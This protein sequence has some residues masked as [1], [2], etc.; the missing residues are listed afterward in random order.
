MLV[1]KVAVQLLRVLGL[2][3]AELAFV[4]FQ[5]VVLFDVLLEALVAGAGEGTLIAAENYSLQ[6]FGEFGPAHFNGDNA[7]LCRNKPDGKTA[8]FTDGRHTSSLWNRTRNSCTPLCYFL[9]VWVREP[10]THV[11]CCPISN[12]KA[13]SLGTRRCF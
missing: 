13:Y 11:Q 12:P 2:V 4:G 5:F 9:S 1:P 6:V 10:H 3:V 7:L 8:R